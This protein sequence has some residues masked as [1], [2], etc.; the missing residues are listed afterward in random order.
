MRLTGSHS[1]LSA[2]SKS[3]NLLFDARRRRDLHHHWLS[4]RR[5]FHACGVTEQDHSTNCASNDTSSRSNAH[6]IARPLRPWPW[7]S[8]NTA[9][10]LSSQTIGF[11]S[12]AIAQF[13]L[14]DVGSFVRFSAV[15]QRRRRWTDVITSTRGGEAF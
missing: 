3:L 10:P 15:G 8:S 11:V 6:R 2:F 14:V 1:G 4:H 9:S 7:I 12:L 13:V 5:K